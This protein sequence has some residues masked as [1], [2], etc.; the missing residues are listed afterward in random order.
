MCKSM[1]EDLDNKS[2][3]LEAAITIA[4]RVQPLAVK[5]P[6]LRARTSFDAGFQAAQHLIVQALRDAQSE[7]LKRRLIK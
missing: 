3:G 7:Q 5:T 1:Y 2:A 4:Q 6:K